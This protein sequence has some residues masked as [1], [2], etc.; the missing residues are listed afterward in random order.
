MNAAE[1]PRQR[2]VRVVRDRAVVGLLAIGAPVTAVRARVGVEHDHT[3]VHV[4]VGDERLVCLRIH[5][6]ASRAAEALGVVAALATLL[7]SD[8]QDE[9]PLAS[10]LQNLA[11]PVVAARDPDVSL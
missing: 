11:F 6:D 5:D 10:E 4:A 7:L 1:L 9:L 2:L 8:L 3:P